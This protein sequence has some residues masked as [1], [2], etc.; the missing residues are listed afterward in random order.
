MRGQCSGVVSVPASFSFTN[1][2]INDAETEA[3]YFKTTVSSNFDEIEKETR[4]IN[5][6]KIDDT[7]RNLK[8][9]RSGKKHLT[10]LVILCVLFFKLEVIKVCSHETMTMFVR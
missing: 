9:K 10:S 8:L 6:R 4:S 7:D 5:E 3:A 1:F 2:Y